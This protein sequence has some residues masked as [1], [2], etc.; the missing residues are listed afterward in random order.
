MTR[1][2]SCAKRSAAINI[3]PRTFPRREVRPPRLPRST[4]RKG[5]LDMKKRGWL[6][7]TAIVCCGILLGTLWASGDFRAGAAQENG[8]ADADLDAIKAAADSY[9]A[10]FNAQD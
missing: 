7:G 3:P 2:R 5:A 10:A 6:A 4:T 9:T 1:S 8:K